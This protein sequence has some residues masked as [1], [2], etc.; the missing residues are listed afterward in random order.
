MRDSS[1]V[2]DSYNSWAMH[3]MQPITEYTMPSH[4]EIISNQ[5]KYQMQIIFLGGGQY[6]CVSQQFRQ[7]V[8]NSSC[9]TS[10]IDG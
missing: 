8:V 4:Y 5:C 9:H 6:L 10:S 3:L 7:V 1:R 2:E